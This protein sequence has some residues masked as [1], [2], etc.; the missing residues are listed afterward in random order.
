MEVLRKQAQSANVLSNSMLKP[1]RISSRHLKKLP[2]WVIALILLVSVFQ[3]FLTSYKE[4]DVVAVHDGDTLT[5]IIDGKEQ[6][7]RLFGIDAP[8]LAQKHGKSSQKNLQQLVQG[9]TLRIEIVN[10]DKFSRPVVKIW[11]DEKNIN[12]AMVE[13]GWA[14]WYAQY[15]PQW[16]ELKNLETTAR[17]QRLGLWQDKHPT[18]P[19]EFR[20]E[21]KRSSER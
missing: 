2:A 3:H 9:K 4:G 6:R 20:Q 14:W 7:L 11:A 17:Q 19:W 13:K 18:P 5:A 10:K 21:T 16:I 8:E 12:A 15:A 1:P